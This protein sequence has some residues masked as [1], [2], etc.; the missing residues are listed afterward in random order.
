MTVNAGIN[1]PWLR[2]IRVEFTGLSSGGG[3]AFES[4]GKPDALRITA[5]VQKN[6]QGIP[7]A[8]N[9]MLY[10]LSKDTRKTFQ[11][12]TTKVRIFA[13]WDEGPRS[14]LEQSFYGSLLTA[15]HNRAGEDIITTIQAVSMIED[16]ARE[17]YI[18]P[19][20]PGTPVVAIV[21]DAVKCLK[22]VN[23]CIIKG[24]EGVIGFKGWAH[25][26]SVRT[27]LDKLSREFSFSWTVTDGCFQAVGDK[28]SLG[29]KATFQ[30]P[31]LIDVNPILSGPLQ[32]AI[33]L[34]VRSTFDATITPGYNVSVNS[35]ISPEYNDDGYRVSAVVHNL[36][37]YT[38]SSFISETVAFKLG[39]AQ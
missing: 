34:K 10:N 5:R 12:D 38:A 8:T 7:A 24:I 39:M 3:K 31:Y 17:A 29:K 30:D 2:R 32:I 23:G 11:R 4:T 28:A 6:I 36:D 26:D 18:Q 27:A 14:G 33:G 19:W 15:V 21:L 13:G 35:Q 37:C 16:F 25:C 1:W 9:L 22:N 20:A